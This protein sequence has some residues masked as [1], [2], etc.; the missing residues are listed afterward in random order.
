[1]NEQRNWPAI[2]ESITAPVVLFG[3]ALLVIGALAAIVV[4][5]S[6]LESTQKLWICLGA[7]IL[8]FLIVLAVFLLTWFRPE[9]LIYS[10]SGHLKR[11]RMELG[12]DNKR[13]P[14]G[15][16]NKKEGRLAPPVIQASAHSQKM[17]RQD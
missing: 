7:D 16:W 12:A 17:G 15:E 9:N 11:M 5:L 13:V 6:G 3:L 2:L 4:P 8:I 10:E 14:K 1:M